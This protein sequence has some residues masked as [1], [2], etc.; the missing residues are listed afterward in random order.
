MLWF[1]RVVQEDSDD[2]RFPEYTVLRMTL[3]TRVELLET[4]SHSVVLPVVRKKSCL[5]SRNSCQIVQFFL[6]AVSD[7]KPYSS[8]SKSTAAPWVCQ[9]RF[10]EFRSTHR[11]IAGKFTGR[12]SRFSIF[13]AHLNCWH[14][15][16]RRKCVT[17]NSCRTD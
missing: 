8:Y 12:S 11:N 7:T 10:H 14:R 4:S 2:G 6:F 17:S 1:L 13:V 16:R 15:K 5:Y 3:F 9:T